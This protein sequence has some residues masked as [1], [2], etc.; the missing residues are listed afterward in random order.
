M[1]STSNPGLRITKEVPSVMTDQTTPIK[2]VVLLIRPR[3]DIL[4]KPS[5]LGKSKIVTWALVAFLILPLSSAKAED[6]PSTIDRTVWN[7]FVE[8]AAVKDRQGISRVYKYVG[9]QKVAVFGNPTG[10][11]LE[12]LRNSIAAINQSCKFLQLELTS[13]WSGDAI[14]FHF[15]RKSE[16]PL[17]IEGASSDY[18]SHLQYWYYSNASLSKTIITL[19]SEEKQSS[20]NYRIKVR[21]LQSIGF[22]GNVSS[23]TSFNAL[24]YRF[25][26]DTA[27]RF[28][29]NDL[30]ALTL[31]CSPELTS[32]MTTQNIGYI[33]EQ[34]RLKIVPNQIN[35][36]IE[37]DS[38]ALNSEGVVKLRNDVYQQFVS[39]ITGL[40]WFLEK[41]GQIISNGT[42][43]IAARRTYNP[44][45]INLKEY[46][47]YR[48]KYVL[49]VQLKDLIKS[50]TLKVFEFSYNPDG[51]TAEE[52]ILEEA[53]LAAEKVALELRA[54]QEAEAKAKAEAE[55]KATS[56]K[57]KTTI[58]CVK[59]KT[60]KK[61]SAIKPK[62][63]AGYKKR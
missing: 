18:P 47:K 30:Q 32:G 20:R 11:D 52:K 45:E 51:Q 27:F 9:A 44:W 6:A 42:I 22:L 49:K 4:V 33:L 57:M 1:N 3:L 37:L 31:L 29:D 12:T 5:N 61:V 59:G 48:S 56:E 34:Y 28:S 58:T 54:R 50:S 26:I 60:T 16:F 41:D 62:C 23:D 55:A 35:I 17:L 25:G 15:V 53:R 43:D 19:D 63:P 36:K 40:D 2:N 38:T 8:T 39:S 7:T 46:L 24:A 14:R 21:L 10:E 13:N